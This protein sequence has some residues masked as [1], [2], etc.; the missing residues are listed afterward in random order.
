MN[1]KN[2]K[3]YFIGGLFLATGILI[4]GI[5]FF[6][7]PIPAK[8]ISDFNSN[9]LLKT[10][11]LNKDIRRI[12]SMVRKIIYYSS[13]KSS[14]SKKT[15]FKTVIN[16]L[17]LGL[18]KTDNQYKEID[19]FIKE[20]STLLKNNPQVAVYFNKSYYNWENISKPILE[21]II[22]YPKYISSKISYKLF[23]MHT[24]Y[25]SYLPT[26]NII[27]NTKLYFKK[28]INTAIYITIAGVIIILCL[29]ILFIY[30]ASKF[31]K[32]IS[33]SEQKF[34]TLFDNLPLIAFILDI[35]TGC[36][37]DVNKA[38]VK[39]YGYS[40]DELLNMSIEKI[41][42]F[43]STQEQAGFRRL[44]AEKGSCNIF[45]QHK[46]KNGE[47]KQI[48][49]FGNAIYLNNKLYL[50]TI[51][52]DITE[53]KLLE[54]KLKESEELFRIMT[55]NLITGVVL[56][57]E[58]YI[59]ANP[60]AENILAYTKDE[61]YQKYVWDLFPGEFDKKAIKNAIEKRLDGEMF[62]STYATIRA[63]TKQNKEIWLLISSTT[64]KYKNKFTALASFIDVSEMVSLRN[65][66]EQERDLFKVLIE[67]IHSGIT[68]YNKDRFIYVNSALLDLFH[69]TKEEFL[70]LNVNDFF[71][72]KEDRLLHQNTS[73]FKTYFNNELSSRFVYIYTDSNSNRINTNTTR[74]NNNIS[75]NGSTS[76]ADTGQSGS[77]SNNNAGSNNTGSG[78]NSL[79]INIDDNTAKLPKTDMHKNINI[80][81]DKIRYID[82]FRTVVTYKGEQTGLAIF[83]DVTDQILREQNILVERE[84]YKELSEIDGLTGIYNRRSFDGKLIELINTALRYS[85]PLSLMM[86]DID[87]FKSINDTYG[88]ETGDFILKEL[89]FIVKENLRAADFFA[90]YGGEEFMVIT[91][92]TNIFTAKELAER[93]RIKIEE[94][95]FSI[96]QSITC[97]FGIT[98]IKEG[99]TSKSI[100]YR[101]D[102]A[103]YEAK[104]AGRNKVYY[105]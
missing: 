59:Y 44:A 97:S 89:S 39:F 28:L 101:A 74:S 48:Q 95:N 35:E 100:V 85:R 21:I 40:K 18:K 6:T 84:A 27:K 69:Y 96:G 87:Y 58:K 52:L 30:Y 103:L 49:S 45:F 25:L 11:K 1:I 67:N 19:A 47:I 55:E 78:N 7:G 57:R 99:D 72:I 9:L 82:L 51:I 98:E 36:F 22:K 13:L 73:V 20:N 75:A 10:T 41:N 43:A 64:V 94:H 16:N 15:R 105:E 80:T 66:L 104:K 37:I 83:S 5:L 31:Y 12:K 26:S 14:L 38:A 23:L 77:S 8:S 53:K 17:K 46:L 90:R 24:I 65:T 34:K 56:Y 62:Q 33:K 81:D 76:G 68:L 63:L 32:T 91:P 29:G 42:I 70:N 102:S 61:L 60:T 50:L 93:L 71:S 2:K 3:I 86:F 79:I 4:A 92:E 88:H 54:D